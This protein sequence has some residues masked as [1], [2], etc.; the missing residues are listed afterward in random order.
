MKFPRLLLAELT[1]MAL[2]VLSP[3]DFQ[4]TASAQE[5]FTIGATY[6]CANK[7]RF[8]VLSCDRGACKM[9]SIDSAS[10]RE[11]NQDTSENY[12]VIYIRNYKCTTAPHAGVNSSDDS[13]DDL[14]ADVSPPAVDARSI[15]L[16]KTNLG[17]FNL[18]NTSLKVQLPSLLADLSILDRT[19]D[20][21]E[22]LYRLP[23]GREIKIVALAYPSTDVSFSMLDKIELEM[24]RQSHGVKVLRRKS[25]RAFLV[26]VGSGKNFVA[27]TNGFRAF[28]TFGVGTDAHLFFKAGIY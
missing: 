22:G 27:W 4:H 5:S 9:L 25:N 24:R 18:I 16:F 10:G 21:A 8:R 13:A 26:D 23:S 19:R 1:A 14:E 15:E 2:L 6:T 20:S 28:F 7:A 3:T 17:D 11:Y 12:I